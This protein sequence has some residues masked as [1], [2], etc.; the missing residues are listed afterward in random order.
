[1]PDLQGFRAFLFDMGNTLFDFHAAG[2]SDEEKDAEGIGRL[3]THCR[4]IYGVSLDRDSLVEHVIAPWKHYVETD[5][6]RALVEM[7]IGDLIVGYVQEAG[8]VVR[9]GDAESILD[10]YFSPYAECVVVNNCA[11]ECLHELK[12]LEKSVCVISNCTL[13]DGVFIR[14]FRETGLDP[15]IDHYLFS[16]S[17][18][19]MK[20]HE[21]MFREAL[22]R[23][24]CAAEQAIM[25]GDSMEADM[26]GAAACGCATCL[27]GRDGGATSA[28]TTDFAI[29]SFGD[30]LG[31]LRR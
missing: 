6:K 4:G 26:Q 18:G 27:Y 3:I 5:R 13:P 24:G 29:G 30:L 31:M 19:R 22:R 21:T 25:I 7:N 16:Y 15:C 2:P 8:C 20:P 11:G 17:S 14:L 28:G 1:M 10:A 23:C 9:P 12:R